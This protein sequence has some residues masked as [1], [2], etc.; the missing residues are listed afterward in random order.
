MATNLK[1]SVKWTST[2]YH[3]KKGVG[4]KSMGLIKK[5]KKIKVVGNKLPQ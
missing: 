3:V 2:L 1:R 5:I 4:G